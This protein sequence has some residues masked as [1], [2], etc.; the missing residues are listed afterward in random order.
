MGIV[1]RFAR[2]FFRSRRHKRPQHQGWLPS[3]RSVLL[4]ELLCAA[5]VLGIL[6]TGGRGRF[7][8][9]LHPRAD[10]AAVA[11]VAILVGSSHLL[12]SVKILPYLRKRA[13]P[14]EYDQQR[15]LLDLGEAARYSNNIS[16]VYKFSVDTIASALHATNVSVLVEDEAT[17]DFLL[18]SSSV[19]APS[20][21]TENTASNQATDNPQ[22]AL[23]R[24]AFVVRRLANLASP[25]RLEKEDLDIWSRA[26][27]FIQG[28][29]TDKRKQE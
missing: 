5:I 20:S 1:P 14:G 25:L 7:L 29:D 11:L 28:L 26:A 19:H 21:Q 22:I 24:E 15:I 23:P 16:D 9:A 18:R 2:R 4:V 3:L 6:L 8:D 10:A 27:A 12:F 17:G 13:S